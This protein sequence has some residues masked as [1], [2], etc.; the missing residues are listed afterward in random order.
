M[1]PA[2]LSATSQGEPLTSPGSCIPAS[3]VMRHSGMAD[4][5]ATPREQWLS[6]AR[7]IDGI[8]PGPWGRLNGW[9][10]SR[11]LDELP[12][13]ELLAA[14][15]R[16]AHAP[17]VLV[18]GAR[19]CQHCVWEVGESRRNAPPEPAIKDRAVASRGEIRRIHGAP[20][21]LCKQGVSGSSPLRSI[22]LAVRCVW[23]ESGFAGSGSKRAPELLARGLSRSSWGATRRHAP[24]TA[25]AIPRG[26]ACW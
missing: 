19:V 24:R 18:S 15:A 3:A 9:N 20:W 16:R 8:I 10:G 17:S 4:D 6:E 22:D 12:G 13:A 2:Q 23:I 11:C 26:S 21:G 5:F 1:G 25:P 14:S 7:S